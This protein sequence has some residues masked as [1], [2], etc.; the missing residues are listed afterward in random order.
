MPDSEFQYRTGI[1]KDIRPRA[2]ID[3]RPVI[4]S[5]PPAAV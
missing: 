5:D 4:G 1:V 2:M 3:A